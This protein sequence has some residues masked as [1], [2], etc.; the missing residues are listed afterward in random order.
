MIGSSSHAALLDYSQQNSGHQC[1]GT[2]GW[3]GDANR[4]AVMVQGE[5]TSNF[6]STGEPASSPCGRRG[7]ED[8]REVRERRA[9]VSKER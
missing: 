2:D 5:N 3:V 9:D 1:L 4:Q 7:D 6:E 8:D